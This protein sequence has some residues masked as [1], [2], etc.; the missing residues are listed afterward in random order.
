MEALIRKSKLAKPHPRRP[1]DDEFAPK[2]S[3]YSK[4]SSR[5]TSPVTVVPAQSPI[6]RDGPDASTSSLSGLTSDLTMNEQGPREDDE[7]A[8]I[9][10]LLRPPSIPGV[11]DWGIPPAPSG[12]CD[13]DLEVHGSFHAA[14]C[15]TQSY[16]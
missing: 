4:D 15:T 12:P 7:I 1:F 10:A 6:K 3:S 16:T 14:Y 5:E 11:E 13:P 2:T 8:A 9:R